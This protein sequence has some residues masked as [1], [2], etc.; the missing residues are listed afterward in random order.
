MAVL[1]PGICEEELRRV[2]RQRPTVQKLPVSDQGRWE[3]W[4]RLLEG[5]D[6]ID[7]LYTNVYIFIYIYIFIDMFICIIYI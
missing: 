6:I 1:S 7:I 5:Q 4:E 3:K 2:D